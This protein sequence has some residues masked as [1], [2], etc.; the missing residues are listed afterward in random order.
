VNESEGFT[1]KIEDAREADFRLANRCVGDSKQS[2]TFQFRIDAPRS[3]RRASINAAAILETPL[4][5]RG[6]L[7]EL[8]TIE[9]MLFNQ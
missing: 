1:K 4:S 8:I 2:Q 5:D 9:A 3:F 7:E 6:T